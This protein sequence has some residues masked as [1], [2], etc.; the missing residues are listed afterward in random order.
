MTKLI[1]LILLV[2]GIALVIFGISASNSIGSDISNLFTGL[3]T[4]RAIWMLIGGGV[5]ALAGLAGTF[6]SP[7]KA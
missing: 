3:P 7:A 5:L 2:S 4:D 6:R 1:S